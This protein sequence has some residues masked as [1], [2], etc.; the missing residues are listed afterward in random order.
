MKTRFLSGFAVFL[1]VLVAICRAEETSPTAEQ[2]AFFEQHVRPLLIERCHKCHA[3]AKQVKGGL[4]LD[5]RAGWQKG[6]ETGPA[7]IPGKPDDSLLIKAVRYDNVDLQM[8]PEGKLS[9]VE[10]ARLEEWVRLGAPDPRQE[11]SPPMA[12]RGERLAATTHW[13][14]QPSQLPSVPSVR[15]GD[16]SLNDIDRYV[17]AV[18]EEKG[19]SPSPDADRYRWLRRVSLDLTGLPPTVEEIQSFVDDRSGQAFESVVDRLLASPAFGERWAR[20]WL[21][22]VGYAD[23]IGSANNVPAEHAWRYRDYVIQSMNLDKSFEE[24]VREQLAGD[25]LEATSIEQRQDQLTATGFLVLGNVNIVE[26]DK[27]VMEMDLVDQQI[28][29]VGKTFLGMTLNCVRCHDHKFDPITLK[30]YYGLAGIFGSTASTYREER[31]VWSSVSKSQLPETLEQFTRR[32]SALRGHEQKVAALQQERTAADARINELDQLIKVAKEIP[33]ESPSP[34]VADWEKERAEVVAKRPAFEQKLWHLNYLQPSPPVAFAVKDAA[35]TADA[36]VQVRGNPHVQGAEMPRGFIQVAT[37]GSVP[38]ID[39]DRSGRL[40]L[41]EWLTHAASPLVSRVAVNRLW[42]RMFGKGLVGSVDYFGVRGELPTHPELLEYLASRF[43]SQGWSQKRLIR[44]LALSRTYRQRTE[45]TET[46]QRALSVDPD[47]HL[48]W[49]MSPRRLDAEMLRDSVLAVSGGLEP[50]SG[51]P[52]LAPEFAENV[53]GLNPKDVNPISFSLNRF[54]DNQQ[55]LRTIYLPVVR[56]SDQRGPAEVLNFFDFPQPAR[57]A[58]DRPTTAVTSQTLFLL[59]GPLL[60]EASRRL[61]IELL[62]QAA[63]TNDVDRVTALYLR[64]MNRAATSEE[65][66]AAQ[67]FLAASDDSTATTT[68]QPT[69]GDAALPW[70]RLIHALMASN[71]FLFRL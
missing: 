63:L 31:G 46:S 25:L 6:G 59:N 40:E 19:L 28:E 56:S 43:V 58:G 52:A 53:G 5:S 7:V 2:T 49:R 39:K 62:S 9:D 22:L 61:A 14:Y 1:V 16:W 11:A 71:E 10:I 54:R 70:Q 15:N 51:G 35:V 60:K 23:Q 64:V 4:R 32:Q 13:A 3:E 50:S 8:P 24:F 55:R 38:V 20:P 69:A 34:Q 18:L 12:A 68:N 45:A 57:L 66:Q 21:D 29:K 47:N 48:Y 44:Q 67:L 65:T 37:H 26:S 36:R 33:T 42:E 27:L 41:A 17:L 30:D